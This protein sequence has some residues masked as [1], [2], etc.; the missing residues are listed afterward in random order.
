MQLEDCTLDMNRLLRFFCNV[1]VASRKMRVEGEK[2]RRWLLE[3]KKSS[4]F[5]KVNFPVLEKRKIIFHPC[6][7][8]Q[9]LSIAGVCSKAKEPFDLEKGQWE[10][11]GNSKGMQLRWRRPVG[12]R[13]K[14][15][16]LKC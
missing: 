3:T 4:G 2:G 15:A 9:I 6:N 13:C 12:D 8:S 14:P 10:R 16:F 5:F 11:S 1:V 7:V